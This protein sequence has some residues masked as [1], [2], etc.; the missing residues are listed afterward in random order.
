[1]VSD[2]KLLISTTIKEESIAHVRK[3]QIFEQ[4]RNQIIVSF[5]SFLLYTSLIDISFRKKIIITKFCL[6]R[7]KNV[8][9]L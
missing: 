9:F 3:C 4:W 8:H 5:L 2:E 1:M 7:V 6:S